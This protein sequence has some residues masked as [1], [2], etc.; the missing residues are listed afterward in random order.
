MPT[1]FLPSIPLRYD[2]AVGESVP[3]LDTS[4]TADWGDPVTLIDAPTPLLMTEFEFILADLYR[5]LHNID[6]NDFVVA[7][8][9]PVLLAA[10]VGFALQKNKRVK[11][12]R[13]DRYM[14]LYYPVD[15]KL[16]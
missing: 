14:Q 3:F 7:I 6:T 8:G 2:R 11:V 9:D 12:L 10:T 13:W 5:Q 16:P 1:V 4:S 15:V